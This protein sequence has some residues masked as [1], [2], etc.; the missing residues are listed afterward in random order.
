[1]GMDDGGVPD[2]VPPNAATRHQIL[3]R[4]LSDVSEEEFVILRARALARKP[5]SLEFLAGVT[6]LETDALEATLVQLEERYLIEK[7]GQRFPHGDQR[8]GYSFR[9]WDYVDVVDRSISDPAVRQ[10]LHCKIGSLLQ[11][12]HGLPGERSYEVFH[13][14]ARGGRL[15]S[16]V[17]N[18]LNAARRLASSFSIEKAILVLDE[19]LGVLDVSEDQ[20]THLQ[21]LREKTSYCVWLR[22]YER[23][24]ECIQQLLSEGGPELDPPLRVELQ[25]GESEIYRLAGEPHRALKIQSKC[26]KLI[27]DAN[28]LLA[29]RWHLASARA[30]RGRGDIKRCQ[31]LCL[32]GIKICNK[33]VEEGSN[34]RKTATSGAAELRLLAQL[35]GLLAETF[36]QRGDEAH[37][38]DHFQLSLEGFERLGDETAMA[39]VLDDLGG[40]VPISTRKGED[41]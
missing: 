7:V 38:V 41:Q 17:K 10:A 32:K 2:A 39:R 15:R 1:M 14:L 21:V 9:I 4:R 35:H 30:R 23:A 26:Y 20:L 36:L 25:I 6:E 37:A 22:E 19:L 16:A 34:S 8:D 24:Q 13:H 18:G 12:Q 28:S 27:P 29:G 33:L 5:L 3:D 11:E 40:V 31:N